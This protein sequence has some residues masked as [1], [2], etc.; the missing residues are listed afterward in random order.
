MAADFPVLNPDAITLQQFNELP[1]EQ[2]EILLQQCCVATQWYRTLVRLRP[3]AS[4]ER[5]LDS[6][7][8]VWE[9]LGESDYLEAFEGHPKIGDVGSLRQ[10]Y[11][12]TAEL[13]G[14][15]QDS[16][17]L[18]DEATLLAL[19]QANDAYEQRNGFIFIICATG[20][21]A[22]EMLQ[23][24]QRRLS[25]D[26]PTEL[27]NAAA[28]QAKI[29]ALR[30]HKLIS[31]PATLS[32]VAPASAHGSA[33]SHPQPD[34]VAMHSS[35]ITTHVLDTQTGK[36]AAGIRVTLALLAQGEWREL[37]AAMTN[38]DGRIAQWM[39]GRARETGEYRIVFE[40]DAYF[41]GKGE[42]C[43]YPRVQIDFRIDRPAE[44]YHVPLL[45]SA[46]GF[47]TYRGS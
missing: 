40:T 44:H 36:P 34:K 41:R 26:R 2:A 10:K 15:E 20:K 18:A 25:N 37:A 27:A 43:F 7:L 19:Q 17:K 24:L 30:L 23:H 39:T 13:A 29:T 4:L 38:E 45:I 32:A 1:A 12:V 14:G 5:L 9:V 21:S 22:P 47:S 6:A 16:V 33:F 31:E 8:Q 3:F 35:P 28:E 46:H 11:A 42:R